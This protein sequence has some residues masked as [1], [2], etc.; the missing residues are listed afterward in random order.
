[1]K[2]RLL[3][4]LLV[5]LFTVACNEK[6]SKTNVSEPQ[7][8]ASA[9][10]ESDRNVL[11]QEETFWKLLYENKADKATQEKIAILLSEGVAVDTLNAD[12]VTPITYAVM[13]GNTNLVELFLQNGAIVHDHDEEGNDAEPEHKKNENLLEMAVEQGNV[14][15]VDLLLK[16]GAHFEGGNEMMLKT[17]VHQKDTE[18]IKTLLHNGYNPNLEIN[19]DGETFTLLNYAIVEGDEAII[20]LLLYAGANPNFTVEKKEENAVVTAVTSEQSTELVA[21]LLGRG[22]DANARYKG[23]PIMFEAIKQNDDSLVEAFLVAGATPFS[24]EESE[25]AFELATKTNQM[26]IANLLQM[27]GW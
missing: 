9:E 27:Y 20:T 5:F 11:S 25:Q 2:W 19:V 24:K 13:E 18:L 1:M 3:G 8:E 17:A 21:R 15:T 12:G 26:K 23:K 14:E 10:E 22:G 4:V 6:N 7:I 16:M